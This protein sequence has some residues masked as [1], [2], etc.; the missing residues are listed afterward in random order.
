MHNAM[1]HVCCNELCYF[2]ITWF[3]FMVIFCFRFFRLC[4]CY[5]YCECS[6]LKSPNMCV[7]LKLIFN[8]YETCH[9]Q[10]WSIVPSSVI[11]SLNFCNI[12]L[13][14]NL[15]NYAFIHQM[16]TNIDW[17]HKNMNNLLVSCSEHNIKLCITIKFKLAYL[18]TNRWDA[19]WHQRRSG[20]R[21]HLDVK[22]YDTNWILHR[23]F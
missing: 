2:I 14:P 18:Q 6:T 21:C 11:M 22:S 3:I 13:K 17:F 4:Y 7:V 10:L 8:S 12:S 1:H 16:F 15:Q 20:G 23:F 19:R 5:G 9:L